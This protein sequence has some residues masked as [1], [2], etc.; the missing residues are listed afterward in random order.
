MHIC[1]A[2]LAAERLFFW[3]S[4]LHI[5]ILFSEIISKNERYGPAMMESSKAMCDDR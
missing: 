4:L 2:S 3:S 5:G 1:T